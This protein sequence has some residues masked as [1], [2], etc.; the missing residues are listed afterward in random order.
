MVRSARIEEKG[1]IGF[2][3]DKMK[4]GLEWGRWKDGLDM[5][6]KEYSAPSYHMLFKRRFYKRCDR[7][8]DWSTRG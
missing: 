1:T 6:S 2:E 7:M 3:D 8:E 5:I 4:I